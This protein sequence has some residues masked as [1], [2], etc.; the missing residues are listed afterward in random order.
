MQRHI[1]K[2]VHETADG[3][4]KATWYVVIN[5]GRD[6]NGRRSQK[7][8]G[9]FRTRKEADAA[10]AKL[11]NEINT[12]VYA[13]PTKTTLKDWVMRSWLPT[14]KS[15]VKPTTWAGLRPNASTP[16]S[17]HPG[18]QATPQAQPY[19]PQRP[20]RAADGG[21]LQEGEPSWWARRQDR[22]PHPLDL[23]QGLS[24][25]IDAG[26][27]A[28]NPADRAKPP[29]TTSHV[30][31][32]NEVLGAA[33]LAEFLSHVSGDRLYA[34][35]HLAAMTGMRRGEALGL[36]WKD[37]DLEAR[38]LAVRHT[39][40]AVGYEITESTPKT[41]QARTIDLDP[42]TMEFLM[43]HQENQPKERDA[44]RP[45]YQDSDLVFS[46]GGRLDDQPSLFSQAFEREMRR[47][48]LPRIRLHD[49]RHTH[50]TIALRAGVTVKVIAERLGH[51]DPAFTM[52]QYAHV[53]PGM[54]A[55]AAEL[56]ASLVRAS[57][58]APG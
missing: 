47:S 54:Q 38:R 32:R 33:Q 31:H 39:I 36:R 12:G 14:L 40:T 37:L 6:A 22:P 17:A 58:P 46:S 15:Q 10:R 21:W 19:S 52:K 48:G 27:L 1:H 20:I 9:G 13:E 25:A 7:W 53:I 16:C 28:T 4:E 2:R 49:L 41:H 8:H 5:L 24:D 57:R 11:V 56:V 50:A 26:L 29:E 23:A 45:G 44:C 34:A 30:A 3:R 18:E 55:E 43:A 35:Y 51:E 42:R